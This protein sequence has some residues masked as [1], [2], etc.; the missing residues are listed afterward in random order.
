M[1]V[2]CPRR[3]SKQRWCGIGAFAI[4][5]DVDV[6]GA[7]SAMH[8]V[9]MCAVMMAATVADSGSEVLERTVGIDIVTIGRV[10][11]EHHVRSCPL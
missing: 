2:Y 11:C 7:I 10:S 9:R 3:S 4:C 8:P 6:R 1:V 5:C